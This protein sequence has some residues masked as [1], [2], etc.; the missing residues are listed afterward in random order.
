MS[1]SY[2]AVGWNS[3]KK[4]YDRMLAAAVALFLTVFIAVGL[5]THA[6]ETAEILLLRATAI[7]AI[8]LLHFIL[9]IGPMARLD[10]RW[11][12]LLYNRR[13]LGVMMFLLALAHS[14][15]AII[16]YHFGGVLNPFVSIFL[17]D[18]GAGAGQFP[19]QGFGFLALLILFVMA[20]TSHDF[21][22]ANLSAPV[23]KTLHMGVYVAYAFLV[24]H[25]VFGVLQSETH[26]AIAVLMGTGIVAIAG[27]HL[28][29]GWRRRRND[30]EPV[31]SPAADGYEEV[32]AVDELEENTPFGVTLGGERVAVLRYDQNKIS[33][34]SGVCQHQN[35]PLTEGR[36]IHGCLTCPWHGY[37][38]NPQDGAS[39]A[40]FTEKIPTFNVRVAAGKVFV[41]PHPNPAGT[42]VE[43]ATV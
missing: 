18:A 4:R 28:F 15:L 24:V 29:T 10:A 1:V 33:A 13:H 26:P 36:F 20:A 5:G 38:Y 39:P 43:P 14:V 7:A 11:L 41:H 32:C 25:V 34:V 3:F 19:F 9:M 22:L 21:W 12:P 6:N 35:G 16:T 8:L 23:W 31:S 40:P 42:A 37:Q 17:S 2:Q 27:L 30:V